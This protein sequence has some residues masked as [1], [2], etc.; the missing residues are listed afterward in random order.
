MKEL[1]K[2][3]SVLLYG[4]DY[5]FSLLEKCYNAGLLNFVDASEEFK[6]E[7]A[8]TLFGVEPPNWQEMPKYFAAEL[9]T[10]DYIDVMYNIL[11]IPDDGIENPD[12]TDYVSI[13]ARI[14]PQGLLFFNSWNQAKIQE[15]AN[16]LGS[17]NILITATIAVLTFFVLIYDK[18]S[19]RINNDDKQQ[20]E[21]LKSQLRKQSIELKKLKEGLNR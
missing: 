20:I 18:I 19:E 14:R 15:R 3:D 11:S 16:S 1:S 12:W 10:L 8:R 17:K 5:Q 9:K 2:E 7:M 21:I 4:K 13:A 6:G